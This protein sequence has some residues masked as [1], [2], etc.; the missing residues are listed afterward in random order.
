MVENGG[1]GKHMPAILA[2]NNPG[3]ILHWAKSLVAVECI[4]CTAVVF[5]KLSI[6]SFYLRIFT[7]KTFRMTAYVIAGTVV[8]NGIAGV[9][10]SLVSCIPLE[11][12]WNPA[13]V[14]AGGAKCVNIDNYWRWISFANILTDVVMLVLPLPSIWSL[15]TS[16]NQKIGLTLIFLTGSVGLISSIV[17]FAIFFDTEG[18]IDGTWTSGNLMIW[19]VT[20]PGVYHLAACLPTLRSLFLVIFPNGRTTTTNKSYGPSSYAKS[21]NKDIPLISRTGNET[22]VGAGFVRLDHDGTGE[23]DLEYGSYGRQANS[24]KHGKGSSQIRV[25]QNYSVEASDH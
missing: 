6:L 8:V 23:Q 12:R 7:K 19:T 24:E 10:T 15:Q 16:K 17:R 13:L 22:N 9:V 2:G 25:T 18:F 3:Q 5:P 1:V 20:E 4:Y 21:A 14:A 11:G